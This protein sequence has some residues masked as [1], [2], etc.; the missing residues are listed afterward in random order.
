MP[1]RHASSSSSNN[2]SVPTCASKELLTLR[3]RQTGDVMI[4]KSSGSLYNN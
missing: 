2:N 1:P 4:S 3:C